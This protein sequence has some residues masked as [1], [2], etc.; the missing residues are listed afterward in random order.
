MAIKIKTRSTSTAKKPAT[1]R[2]STKPAAKRGTAATKRNTRSTSKPKAKSTPTGSTRRSSKP[3]VSDAQLNKWIKQ[4]YSAGDKLRK[5]QV[6]HTEAVDNVNEVAQDALAAG[7]PMKIVHEQTGV[8]RQWLYKMG[9]SNKRDNGSTPERAPR[10]LDPEDRQRTGSRTTRKP[11][12][13]ASSAKPKPM[14]T[15]KKGSQ[16]KAGRA[17]QATKKSVPARRGGI[18]IK[19]R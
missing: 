9:Q 16:A 14:K 19:T 18:K 7:V 17:R 5:T 3:Q 2:A 10:T 13:K 1:K 15:V 8:S 12:A 4:L 6:A 11:A